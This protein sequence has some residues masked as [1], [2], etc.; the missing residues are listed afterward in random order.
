[1]DISLQWRHMTVTASQIISLLKEISKV[2][3]T[4]RDVGRDNLSA[5]LVTLQW[6]FAWSLLLI[7]CQQIESIGTHPTIKTYLIQA[8]GWCAL[9]KILRPFV[10]AVLI[11]HTPLMGVTP[12]F[13]FVSLKPDLC[14]TCVIFQ[15]HAI[16]CYTVPRYIKNRLYPNIIDRAVQN[17]SLKKSSLA[18]GFNTSRLN[19]NTFV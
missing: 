5:M 1:M 2:R 16:S 7:G 10:S 13:L 15:L 19:E 17:L 4:S 9:C 3:L 8:S 18:I 6:H 11:L 12:G 14:S